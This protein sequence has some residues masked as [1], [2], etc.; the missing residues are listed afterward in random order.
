MG[1]FSLVR[2]YSEQDRGLNESS[3]LQ[4][5]LQAASEGHQA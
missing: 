5:F 2:G 1:V 3:V 4:E